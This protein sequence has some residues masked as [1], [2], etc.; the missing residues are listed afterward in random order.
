MLGATRACRNGAPHAPSVERDR[1]RIGRPRAWST[2]YGAAMATATQTT[3]FWHPFADMGAVSRSELVIERGEG[4]YVFDAT[5]GATSTA[6]RASGTPTS[7]TGGGRSPTAVAAQM[8]EAGG[9]LD[10]RRLRQPPGQRAARAARRARAD[11]GRAG[12]SS[13]PAAA[14][15]S[16]PRRRSRAG[17]GSLQGQPERVHIISRSERLPRHARLRHRD[18]RH[19]GQ[20]QQLGPAGPAHARPSQHDSLPALEAGDP[21]RRARARRGVLLRAGDRRR[22]RAP[23]AGGLHRGRRRPV[24]A[25]TASCSSSTP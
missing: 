7:A 2:H 13:P 9:L 20:R 22:R 10:V 8:A 16:T 24:R 1:A 6:R 5:A 14:T 4:V 21:A 15:R 11:G 25:S 12:S 18:R 3:S 23:A 19:R 17:T